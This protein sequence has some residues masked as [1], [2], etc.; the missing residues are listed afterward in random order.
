[1]TSAFTVAPNIFQL[2]QPIGGVEASIVFLLANG[3]MIPAL[4]GIFQDRF[5]CRCA[6][7]GGA[8]RA[9]AQ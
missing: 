2:F 3:L 4:R 5:S 1:M 7:A 9:Q 8:K 6:D